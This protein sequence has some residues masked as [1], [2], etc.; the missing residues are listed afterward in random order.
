MRIYIA[1]N[2]WSG[3]VNFTLPAPGG[4]KNWY[5]VTDTC[6]WADGPD[7]ASMPGTETLIGGQNSNYSLCGRALLLLMAK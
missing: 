1:Y 6:N 3:T 5:R 2:G 4:G 7:S